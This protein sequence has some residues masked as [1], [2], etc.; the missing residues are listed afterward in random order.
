MNEFVTLSM[1]GVLCLGA[2]LGV[3]AAVV[4][5]VRRRRERRQMRRHVQAIEP[6][7]WNEAARRT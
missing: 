7:N 5:Q 6:V 3:G 2:I 4:M 1:I